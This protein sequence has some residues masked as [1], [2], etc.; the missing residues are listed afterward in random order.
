VNWRSSSCCQWIRPPSIKSLRRHRSSQGYSPSVLRACNYPENA[1]LMALPRLCKSSPMPRVVA[2]PP[3]AKTT[4][5][6]VQ[7]SKVFL[8]ILPPKPWPTG[9]H[10]RFEFYH[11]LMFRS[12]LLLTWLLKSAG[13]EFESRRPTN[14]QLWPMCVA[15]R[16]GVMVEGSVR[17]SGRSKV[18][19]LTRDCLASWNQWFSV[20]VDSFS[21]SWMDSNLLRA[22]L[23]AK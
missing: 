19:C 18:V 15:A 6:D 2:H 11:L 20:F 8:F 9:F 3:R 23:L 10:P 12:S 7:R 1:L 13:P 16:L 22:Y 4:K 21:Q 17:K 14:P 5:S